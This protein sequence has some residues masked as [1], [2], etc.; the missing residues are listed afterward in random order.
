MLVKMA[1]FLVL[2]ADLFHGGG[3]GGGFIQL[4]HN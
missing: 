1:V 4:L 3:G 2:V